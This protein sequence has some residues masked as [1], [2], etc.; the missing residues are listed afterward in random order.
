MVAHLEGTG[1]A[2]YTL[3]AGFLTCTHRIRRVQVGNALAK[4]LT[5]GR[6]PFATEWTENAVVQP[7][8][9]TGAWVQQLT[10][11]TPINPALLSPF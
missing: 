8:G 9:C 2:A 5:V 7:H 11:P 4:G 6:L 10:T 3:A 1:G